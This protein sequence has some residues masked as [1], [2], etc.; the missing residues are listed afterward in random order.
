MYIVS[1]ERDDLFKKSETIKNK[2][3]ILF[4]ED[5]QSTLDDKKKKEI[6]KNKAIYIPLKDYIL[7]FFSRL[8]LGCCL[9][10]CWPKYKSFHKLFEEGKSKLEGE[11]DIV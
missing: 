7:L 1:T 2:N 3:K 8:P 10:Y 9:K 4:N 11:M 6:K 5:K